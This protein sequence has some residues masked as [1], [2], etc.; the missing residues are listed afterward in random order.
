LYQMR[1]QNIIDQMII[2]FILRPEAGGSKIVFGSLDHPSDFLWTSLIV[3][4][5]NWQTELLSTSLLSTVGATTIQF[6]SGVDYIYMGNSDLSKF[7][8]TWRLP[9]CEIKDYILQCWCHPPEKK[10]LNDY[11]PLLKLHIGGYSDSINL[12]LR[13]ESYIYYAGDN[14]CITYL[15]ERTDLND[16]EY[17]IMGSPLYKAF[18]IAHDAET[19]RLGFRA[20]KDTGSRLEEVFFFSGT[21]TLSVGLSLAV[22]LLMFQMY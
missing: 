7:I 5:Q 1:Q 19:Y 21:K 8:T 9:L 6:D 11:F 12:F 17:W 3:Q 13:P 20:V 2:T 15:R 16:K 18:D 22:S 10:P 4:A 14:K